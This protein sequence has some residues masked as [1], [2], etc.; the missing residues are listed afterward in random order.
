MNTI[1]H[2]HRSIGKKPI[3]ADYSSLRTKLRQIVQLLNLKFVIESDLL[4]TKIFLVNI[5]KKICQK[6]FC[7]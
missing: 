7:Y 6:K 3:D 4:S 2:H 1:I 5:A